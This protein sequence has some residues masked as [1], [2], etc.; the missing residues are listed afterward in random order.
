M[1][2]IRNLVYKPSL[3]LPPKNLFLG[4][5]KRGCF[6]ALIGQATENS[7]IAQKSKLYRSSFEASTTL[8]DIGV[9]ACGTHCKL[10]FTLLMKF[11]ADANFIGTRISSN[12]ALLWHL[13]HSRLPLYSVCDGRIYGTHTYFHKYILTEHTEQVDNNNALVAKQ[14][15]ASKRLFHLLPPFLSSADGN[16]R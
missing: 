3:P 1:L 12:A 9:T 6:D 14:P 2:R 11:N 7:I 10:Y 5:E 16:E 4:N 8:T 15:G 13:R